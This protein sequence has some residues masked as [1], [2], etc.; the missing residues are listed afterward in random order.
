MRRPLLALLALCCCSGASSPAASGL[1]EALKLIAAQNKQLDTLQ[2]LLLQALEAPNRTDDVPTPTPEEAGAVAGARALAG[3]TAAP[4]DDTALLDGLALT[5]GAITLE[6]RA[7]HRR[8]TWRLTKNGT[9]VRG[10]AGLTR[11]VVQQAS[12]G[13]AFSGISISACPMNDPKAT[14]AYGNQY[15]RDKPLS[16][17]YVEGISIELVQNQSLDANGHCCGA[18]PAGNAAGGT[19]G[20]NGMYGHHIICNPNPSAS[21]FSRSIYDRVLGR[22]VRSCRYQR[23]VRARDRH[24]RLRGSLSGHRSRQQR[25]ASSHPARIDLLLLDRYRNQ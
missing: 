18:G 7:Y 8:G 24:Q 13:E 20:T 12:P 3:A 6:P 23:G 4:A 5:G 25:V 10:W 9:H 1:S 17:V 22:K 21:P 19:G 14:C 16:H 15:S 2:A 11:L